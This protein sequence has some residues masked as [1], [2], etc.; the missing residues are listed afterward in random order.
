M[1]V[2]V[3]CAVLVTQVFAHDYF[4]QV[5]CLPRRT[6]RVVQVPL[7]MGL[8]SLGL[9]E[10]CFEDVFHCYLVALNGQGVEASIG[11]GVLCSR[12]LGC[13]VPSDTGRAM[14]PGET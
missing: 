13:R 7:I 10:L 1:L 3:V 6:S 4:V 2:N 11:H 9:R 8:P 5:P 12:A 14:S